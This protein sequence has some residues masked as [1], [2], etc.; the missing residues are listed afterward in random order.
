LPSIVLLM[1]VLLMAPISVTLADDEVDYQQARQLR[2]RGEVL[3]LATVVAR[4]MELQ[5]GRVLGV[6]FEHEHGRWV[7]EIALLAPDGV[8]WEFEVDAASGE[9]LEREREY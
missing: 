2:D 8:V 3:P 7:Y 5:P 9:L 1:S 4:V 6:E